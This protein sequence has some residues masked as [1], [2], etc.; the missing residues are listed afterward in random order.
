VQSIRDL[1]NEVDWREIQ[2]RV[3]N[4]LQ[5]FLDLLA[6]PFDFGVGAAHPVLAIVGA[7]INMVAAGSLIAKEAVYYGN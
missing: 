4:A 7:G 3:W 2:K 1:I 6:L 5:A